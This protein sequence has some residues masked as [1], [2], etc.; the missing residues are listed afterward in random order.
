MW[1][2][3]LGRLAEDHWRVWPHCDAELTLRI[4]YCDHCDTRKTRSF[5]LWQWWWKC[6]SSLQ[7]HQQDSTCYQPIGQ[8]LGPGSF[9]FHFWAQQQFVEQI[10][11][12]ASSLRWDGIFQRC[13][14][15][16]FP[17]PLEI[18]E[19]LPNLPQVGSSV[20]ESTKQLLIHQT[21]D[22]MSP[23]YRWTFWW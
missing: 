16:F 10:A 6:W 2:V 11:V 14:P 9:L 23:V 5:F 21:H 12:W 18:P 15:V 3:Q 20:R 1:A 17:P 13:N 7:S 19:R 4:D 8:G 22:E